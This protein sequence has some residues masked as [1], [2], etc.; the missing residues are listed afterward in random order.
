MATVIKTTTRL[1]EAEADFADRLKDPDT[2]EAVALRQLTGKDD[3]TH[4]PAA[5]VVHALIEAGITVVKER[6]EEVG[7]ARL[8][9]FLQT[10]PEH[11]AWVNSRRKRAMLRH[12]QEAS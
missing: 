1:G 11:Q 8:S 9:E 6:A 10:D 3:L 2:D 12:G 5:T 7:L 4:A